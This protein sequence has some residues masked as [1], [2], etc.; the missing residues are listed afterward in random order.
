MKE[1]A[2][3]S[4]TKYILEKYHLNA[5]KKYGQNFL[6]DVNIIN[7]I[8]T[9]AKIDQTTAVIEV[10]PGIGAL[11][12]V[13]GRYSGKVTSFEID[14]RFMP[15]YQEFLNQDNIEII[16]GDF[17]E[18]DI[19]PIVDQLKQR[20]QKVCLVAN[21][22]YY[23]TTAI[24]EKVVLGNFGIDEMIVMVQKEVALKMTGIYK[25]P[26][27]LMIKDMGTI[28]YLFT[29]NKNVF[30]PAPHVDSAILK[31]ELKKAPDLKLYEVLNICFKQRRKTI[32]KNLKQSY[33]EAEEILLQTGIEN[34]KR[35]EELE[36]ADFKNITKMI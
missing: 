25:N 17:M 8:V 12:Q 24:I 33:E 19:K 16:F 1:I 28:E 14:E 29:V 11:T 5:L 15:V 27:L 26:L 3:P 7:K 13:L 31:I 34:R 9:S 21:L 22:P 20:Y 32:L 10:G 30:M 36:L 6:I 23:I 4:T 18:Q 2:T 35:S